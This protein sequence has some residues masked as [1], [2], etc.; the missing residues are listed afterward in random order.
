MLLPQKFQ[1]LYLTPKLLKIKFSY[2]LVF[3]FYSCSSLPFISDRCNFPEQ[4]LEPGGILNLK[5][6]DI[7]HNLL[8]IDYLECGSGNNKR[9][10][11][12]IAYNSDKRLFEV[13]GV[14][15]EEKSFPKIKG[16]IR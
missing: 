9:I 3:V 15:I 6:N 4:A 12:P 11:A 8:H 14:K 2:L 1:K 10:I 13:L 5:K 16:R 7:N